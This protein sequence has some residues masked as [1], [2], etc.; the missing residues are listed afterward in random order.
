MA[1]DWPI[2]IFPFY[3]R[4]LKKNIIEQVKQFKYSRSTINNGGRS[5]KEIKNK[6]SKK[7]KKMAFLQK[8]KI[9]DIKKC[10]YKNV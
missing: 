6:V 2:N 3:T 8:K 4:S 9:I 1:N 7:K 5:E 10:R